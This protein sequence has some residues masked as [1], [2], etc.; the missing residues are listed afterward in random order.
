MPVVDQI[1][2]SGYSGKTV[3]PHCAAFYQRLRMHLNCAISRLAVS[4]ALRAREDA[5]EFLLLK[6][7]DLQVTRQAL[8]NTVIAL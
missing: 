4:A 6:R 8:C 1:S 5:T 2:I 3:K 7:G